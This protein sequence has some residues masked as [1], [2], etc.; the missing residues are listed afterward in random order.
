MRLRHLCL[1][2]VSILV[3]SNVSSETSGKSPATAAQGATANTSAAPSETT[4][5]VTGVV[6]LQGPA[7]KAKPINMAPEPG[8]AKLHPTPFMTEEVVV[9]ASGG[10]KNVIVYVSEGLGERTFE[11][12]QEPV[13]INQKGCVYY[14]HVVALQANQKLRFVNSDPALHNCHPVPANNPEWNK[15]LPPG[16]HALEVSFARAEIGIPVKCNVHPWMRC[17]IGVFK[18]PYFAVSANNGSFDLKNLRPGK[19]TLEAWH[20]K[21]GTVVQEVIIGPHETKTVEFVF[22]SKALP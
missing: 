19:Y 3:I 21:F 22:K 9:G 4:G 7:P 11:P 6:K 16:I 15:A 17:Y 2:V 5:S 20:E 10:L 8:C 13:V 1:V 18:H 12:P 14:P